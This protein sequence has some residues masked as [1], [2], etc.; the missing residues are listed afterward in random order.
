MKIVDDIAYALIA[1]M[2]LALFL[3]FAVLFSQRRQYMTQLKD[4]LEPTSEA[5]EVE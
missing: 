2:A 5:T 1:L 4:D 3:L